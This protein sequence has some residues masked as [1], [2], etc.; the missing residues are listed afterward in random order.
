MFHLINGIFKLGTNTTATQYPQP[1]KQLHCVTSGHALDLWLI[2]KINQRM[3]YQRRDILYNWERPPS[4]TVGV[5]DHRLIK[6]MVHRSSTTSSD[7]S[8]KFAGPKSILKSMIS[9]RLSRSR[10]MQSYGLPKISWRR[11]NG[12]RVY[13]TTSSP[14]FSISWSS[15]VRWPGP[16]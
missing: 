7:L 8:L 14:T 11:S 12:K 6:C 10:L 9:V 15:F 4:N 1:A 13:L 5:F 2:N 3:T 16:D